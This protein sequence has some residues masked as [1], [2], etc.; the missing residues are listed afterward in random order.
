MTV[1]SAII[2]LVVFAIFAY[3]AYWI[4]TKFLPPPAQMPA[5]AIVGVVLL[6]ILLV[7]FVPEVGNYRLIL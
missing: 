4:I 6:I 7:Q 1:I 2:A 5:L 3:L